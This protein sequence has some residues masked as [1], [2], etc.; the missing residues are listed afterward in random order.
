MAKPVSKPDWTVG[1]PDFGTVTVEPS[2][3]KKE[4]GWL[5]DE[6]IPREFLNWLFFNITDWILLQL[7]ELF[8]MHLLV[9]AE[10]M[11]ILTH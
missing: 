6:R 1:N 7:K 2:A 4:T 8:M 9:L 10:L 11:R 5:V 3:A